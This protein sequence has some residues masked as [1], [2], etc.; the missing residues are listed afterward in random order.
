MYKWYETEET[1]NHIVI[2]SRVRLA[3][4]LKDIPFSIRMNRDATKQLLTDV[5]DSIMETLNKE[6][7]EYR[8]IE[9]ENLTE[10]EK[11]SMMEQH[12]ISPVLVE[13]KFPSGLL[14][15]ETEM[16]SIMLNEEDHIRIQSIFPG[17]ALEKAFQAAD[18]VDNY[19]EEKQEYAFDEQYGYL[20]SCP[21][22]VGTGLR[23]SLMMH[24]FGL[25]KTGQLRN[26]IQAISKFGITVRGIYGEGTEAMG[27]IYQISN[28]VTLGQSEE[29]IIQNL[30]N[31]SNLVIEQEQ[32]LREKLIK[33]NGHFVEDQIYRSYGILSY[34]RKIS[35]PEAMEYLSAIREGYLLGILK[36]KKPKINI[37]QMMIQIQSGC[38]QKAYGSVL[39]K[40]KCDYKR[41]DFIRQQLKE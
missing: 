26:V 18:K 20:T 33:E 10:I 1:D 36:E 22:N 16:S 37:Y 5:K 41:A 35:A 23:A 7:E 39:S 11:Y 30:K 13:K 34:A 27:S 32:R 9:I 38:I 3:R 14:V 15:N 28:Q 31:V 24:L 8:F 25:E 2:S 21:T 12:M 29:E 6:K 40:E 19:I 17:E 4:N